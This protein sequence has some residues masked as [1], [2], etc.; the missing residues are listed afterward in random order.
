MSFRTNPTQLYRPLI[1]VLTVLLT[2]NIFRH[3]ASAPVTWFPV[4]LGGLFTLLL[5]QIPVYAGR[6]GL[7]LISAITL[8]LTFTSGVLP[9]TLAALWGL[10]A[11]SLIRL[12]VQNRP[13][14]GE[15]QTPGGI[16]FEIPLQL[17]P[18]GITVLLFGVPDRLQGTY[19]T[20]EWLY[21]LLFGGVFGLVQGLLLVMDLPFRRG[22]RTAETLRRS[23]AVALLGGLSLLALVGVT[24]FFP[25][26][27]DPFLVAFFS[28]LALF[29]LT[30]HRLSINRWLYEQ[31]LR[32]LSILADVSRSLSATIQLE[33]LLTILQK[34]VTGYLGVDNFYIALFDRESEELWYPLAVKHGQRVNWARR[35]TAD[36]LTDHVILEGQ[37]I[38]IGRDA[39]LELV[40]AGMPVG[41]DI[42]FSWMGVP[43]ISEQQT[44]GCLGVFSISRKVEFSPDDL[45]ILTIIAGQLSVAVENALLY[46]QTQQRSAQLETLNKLSGRLTSSLNLQELLPEI[47]QAIESVVDSRQNAIFLKNDRNGFEL[48]SATGIPPQLQNTLTDLL[49]AIWESEIREKTAQPEHYYELSATP[50]SPA[51]RAL[52][53]SAGILAWSEFPLSTSAGLLGYLVVFYPSPQPPHAQVP[54]ILQTLASQAAMAIQNAYLYAR[55]DQAL[56]IRAKQ[57]TILEAVGQELLANFDTEQVFQLILQHALEFTASPW[58]CICLYHLA[59]GALEIMAFAGYDFE[60][61]TLP[62]ESGITWRCIRERQ[63]INRGDVTQDPEFV[64][65]TPGQTRSQLSVPFIY[66]G[67]VK[68]VM[69][70]ESPRLNAYGEHEV[71]LVYQL[72]N[73]ASLAIH[74]AQLYTE[75]QRRLR[76]Q[77]TLFVVTSHLVGSMDLDHLLQVIKEAL[78]SAVQPLETAIYLFDQNLEKYQRLFPPDPHTHLPE[79]LSPALR[80][81]MIPISLNIDILKAPDSDPALL[82]ELSIGE[83][84]GGYFIPLETTKQRLG[85]I[86]L[87]FERERSLAAQ[88]IQLLQALLAQIT[89]AFENALLF[90]DVL[91]AHDRLAT[92]LNTIEEGILVV[93][94]RGRVVVANQRFNTYC[95]L[96]EVEINRQ[97]LVQLPAHVL[98]VLGYTPAQAH[99][100]VSRLERGL[101]VE[102]PKTRLAPALSRTERIL[103]R[104]LIPVPGRGGRVIGAMIV[105]RD[106]TEEVQIQQTRETITDTL[107][108]DLRS[109]MTAIRAALDILAETV[110]AEGIHDELAVQALSLGQNNAQKVLRLIDSL[111]EI[112][113]MQSGEI[114][115]HPEGLSLYQLSNR[116][117]KDHTILANEYGVFLRNEIPPD[118]PEVRVDAE[119]IERVFSNLIDNALKYSPPGGTVRLSAAKRGDNCLEIRVAD[120]GP[121][122]PEEFRQAI[123]ERFRKVP[124][125]NSKRHGTGLGLAFCR[126]VIE[127]HG[128]EIWVDAN[129]PAGSIF[130]FSLPLSTP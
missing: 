130:S 129:T 110:E 82:Q 114:E 75:L 122:V 94:T 125:Q 103:E 31:R 121:G 54:E 37:P 120:E 40:R 18:L 97:P 3:T 10:L 26:L 47:S 63:L 93:D 92:I 49:N 83:G 117:V 67:Q 99:D 55:T 91:D 78:D 77:S 64:N 81:K 39:H 35:P 17:L 59:E 124:H 2:V 111:L 28:I 46:E 73:Y 50:F 127:A 22:K 5:M 25:E 58:G 80:E 113:R 112:S 16:F 41:E 62:V 105:L 68:G 38:L 1:W 61:K 30:L 70:L 72:A 115:L 98:N 108:H 44:V 51:E 32:Q 42:L 56:E 85:A 8:S 19:T 86:L 79:T 48:V 104:S 106:A 119:K 15:K 11:G 96:G 13:A 76:E 128:G 52:A 101:A 24:L 60:G 107:I 29:S 14:R 89:I 33:E 116:V 66:E 57:L 90:N 6:I 53:Q 71:T 69:T 21:L 126:L 102:S 109:P 36:R 12:L 100:L 123:F 95:G 7:T 20:G 84:G 4:L 23:R 9:A 34:E 65:L 27:G 74:N 118:L 87:A 43:L 45:Q 88:Q